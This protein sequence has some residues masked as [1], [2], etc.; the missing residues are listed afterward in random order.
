MEK[1]EREPIAQ[2]VKRTD[3][4]SKFRAALE[5]VEQGQ[6]FDV[7]EGLQFRGNCSLTLSFDG[8][9]VRLASNNVRTE[10]RVK[11]EAPLQKP[12]QTERT[13]ER[14]KTK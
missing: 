7:F 13:P 3:F 1:R 11:T 14:N 4:M 2:F 5:D 6:C 9:T 10:V 8:V 12:E